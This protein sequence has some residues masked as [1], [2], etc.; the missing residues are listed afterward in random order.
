M[1]HAVLVQS[2]YIG[3]ANVGGRK[4]TVRKNALQEIPNG[5]IRIKV[6]KVRI[7]NMNIGPGG[8]GEDTLAADVPLDVRA[9]VRAVAWMVEP[10]VVLEDVPEDEQGDIPSDERAEIAIRDKLMKAI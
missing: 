3:N 8:T 9:D 1:V 2:A 5:K 7:N 10:K 4:T 6:M